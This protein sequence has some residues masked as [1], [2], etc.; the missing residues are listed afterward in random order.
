MMSN[1]FH[2]QGALVTK[3]SNFNYFHLIP[4]VAYCNNKVTQRKIAEEGAIPTLVTYLNQPPS[5]EVQVEV[6]IALG[7]IVL[8]NTRNQELL[9]E[10]PGFNFDVLL[11]L[12]KS[13]SEASCFFYFWAERDGIHR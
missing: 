6:A 13:K 1:L 4:G 8:S 2:N 9:Q 10:E 12:L 5:E 3:K 7:C 11:D